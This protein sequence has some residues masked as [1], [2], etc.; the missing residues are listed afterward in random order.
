MVEGEYIKA[1]NSHKNDLILQFHLEIGHYISE[2]KNN[3]LTTYDIMN[4]TT[5]LRVPFEIYV[6]C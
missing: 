2:E 6:W 4:A 5:K 3:D 1:I